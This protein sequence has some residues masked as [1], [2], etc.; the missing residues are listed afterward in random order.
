[1]AQR[2]KNPPAVQETWGRSLGGEG[3]LETGIV[4]TSVLLPG[5]SHGQRSIRH[6]S[7]GLELC[8]QMC[9]RMPWD[10]GPGVVGFSLNELEKTPAG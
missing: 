9:T 4:P 2:V 5:G 10:E 1:M 7:G 8:H 3:P 6:F